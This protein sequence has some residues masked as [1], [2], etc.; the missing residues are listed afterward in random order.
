ME[1]CVNTVPQALQNWLRKL[2]LPALRRRPAFERLP[3]TFS[4]LSRCSCVEGPV[5]RILSSKTPVEGTPCRKLSIVLRKM[6][7]AVDTP[8]G[9]R[10]Y[11][12]LPL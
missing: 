12:K 3:E 5:I 9:R 2:A 7:G 10:L 8:Y 1:T 11:L 4:V 6:P